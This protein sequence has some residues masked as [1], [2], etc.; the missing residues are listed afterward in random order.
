MEELFIELWDSP[1]IDRIF[2]KRD[3][4][5]NFNIYY[6]G[7]VF[8]DYPFDKNKKQ[9][10]VVLTYLSTGMNLPWTGEI[11]EGFL[12]DTIYR[13]EADC[14]YIYSGTSIVYDSMSFELYGYGNTKEEAI[15]DYNEKLEWINTFLPEDFIDTYGMPERTLV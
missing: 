15:A 12:E 3:E 13:Y 6:S 9:E 5:G 10:D 11:L 2:I 1:C 8:E 7:T 4:N 14:R